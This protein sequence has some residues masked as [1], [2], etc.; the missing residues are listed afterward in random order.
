MGHKSG[1]VHPSATLTDR[2][3]PFGRSG[4]KAFFHR[5][6]KFGRSAQ[7]SGWVTRD[8]TESAL[9][10]SGS[11]AEELIYADDASAPQVD[12]REYVLPHR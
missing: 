10:L 2:L 1:H 11:L 7:S 3:F 5:V 6:T 4:L 9:H 12:Y 8:W